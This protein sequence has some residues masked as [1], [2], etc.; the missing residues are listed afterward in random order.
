M[1]RFRGDGGAKLPVLLLD[2]RTPTWP[3][4]CLVGEYLVGERFL[5]G[6]RLVG[7]R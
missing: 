6:D 4:R 5:L 7:E 1:L 2:V 3:T